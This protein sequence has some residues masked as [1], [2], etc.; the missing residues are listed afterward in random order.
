MVQ[1]LGHLT[2]HV[3]IVLPTVLGVWWKRATRRGAIAGMIAGLASGTAY[4][5]YVPP[6]FMGNP[7]W[8][9]I[10][11]LLFGIIGASVCL[12]LWLLLV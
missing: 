8:L 12:L 11:H 9:G 4:L 1:L 7:A 10:D 5:I 6:K 2:L 3:W